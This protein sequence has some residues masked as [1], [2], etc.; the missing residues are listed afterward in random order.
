VALWDLNTATQYR[1]Q[2]AADQIVE[3]D[4]VFIGW[5]SGGDGAW[6]E[7]ETTEVAISV[8]TEREPGWWARE[9]GVHRQ[10]HWTPALSRVWPRRPGW[11]CADCTAS[12]PE[13]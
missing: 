5:S 7:G 6:S 8:F 13:P 4:G 9:R 10:R 2:F 1:G 12:A 11:R 3:R